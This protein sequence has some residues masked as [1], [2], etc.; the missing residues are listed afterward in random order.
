MKPICFLFSTTFLFMAFF[1]WLNPV[2]AAI[3]DCAQIQSVSI[4][5]STIET[6]K[7][8]T[9][10]V[11]VDSE[12]AG[13]R[14]ITC[15]IAYDDKWPES[16][17]PDTSAFRT[18]NGSTASFACTFLNVYPDAKKTLISAYDFRSNCGPSTGKTIPVSI[19]VNDIDKKVDTNS[20]DE[21][22]EKVKKLLEALIGENGPLSA[23]T[24]EN[25]LSELP[26][27]TASACYYAPTGNLSINA[28]TAV[29]D[30]LKITPSASALSHKSDVKDCSANRAI[31]DQASQATGVPWQILAGIHYREGNCGS[32][33]SLV[34]GTTIGQIE[35]DVP[36]CSTQ[37][38]GSGKPIP[39][40][41]GCGFK[42]LLDSAIYAG[43]ILKQKIGG[44]P[45][46]LAELMKA[47]SLYNG[48]GN[49]NCGEDTAYAGTC[50]PANVGDDDTYVMNYFDSKHIPMYIIFCGNNS[51]CNPP[52]IDGRIGVLT[53]IQLIA[54]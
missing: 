45:K 47:L 7:D 25:A 39:I 30:I 24:L 17:C 26:T 54:Q 15:G 18:W 21:R 28:V 29:A 40:G 8:L 51:K 34:S 3:D 50:P 32:N 42:S 33:S 16:I 36:S 13:S 20:R 19:T 38:A 6:G 49:S 9:C 41:N 35:S 31:Y 53:A 2:H 27:S 43:N 1:I 37:D 22:I 11:V 44:V 46:T 23:A 10:N 52:K 14:S 12:H 48:G 5:P 4:S